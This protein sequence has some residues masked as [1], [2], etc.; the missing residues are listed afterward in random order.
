MNTGM[1]LPVV[2]GTARDG[3]F[4]RG[5]EAVA[6]R[7]LLLIGRASCAVVASARDQDL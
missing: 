4:R 6:E 5:N 1:V 7:D 2:A 3:L